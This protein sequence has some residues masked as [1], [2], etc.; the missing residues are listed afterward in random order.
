MDHNGK[1][2]FPATVENSLVSFYLSVLFSGKTSLSIDLCGG[3]LEEVGREFFWGSFYFNHTFLINAG[4]GN[5]VNDFV[6]QALTS[7]TL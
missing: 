4:L 2:F 1:S 6:I 7:V 5:Y 3:I